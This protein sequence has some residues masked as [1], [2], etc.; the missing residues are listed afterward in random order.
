VLGWE[1]AGALGAI[2]C[3][4]LVDFLYNAIG[5]RVMLMAYRRKWEGYGQ[6]PV[7]DARVSITERALVSDL[8]GVTRSAAWPSVTELFRNEGYWIFV[9]QGDA[10]FAPIRFFPDDQAERAFVAAAWSR[11]G[12][13]AKARSKDAAALAGAPQ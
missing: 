1:I 6:S 11:M 3:V 9:V 13:D 8:S 12:A 7:L 5:S 10:I 4:A 2:I